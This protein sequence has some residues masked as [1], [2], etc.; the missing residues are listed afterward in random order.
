MGALEQIGKVASTII[1]SLKGQPLALALV[2]VN[3]MFLV[4]GV[5]V[6]NDRRDSNVRKDALIADLVKNCVVHQE[7]TP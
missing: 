4:G 6:L 7:K 5:Y 2:V 3:L 1:E